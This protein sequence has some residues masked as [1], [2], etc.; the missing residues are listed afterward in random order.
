MEFIGSVFT[1]IFVAILIGAA[2]T[3]GATL[4]LAIIGASI[5]MTLFFLLR[6]YWLRWRFLRYAKK[7]EDEATHT[8]VTIIETDYEDVTDKK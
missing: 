8:R 5:L 7:R 1:V 6:G 2:L 4:L 3:L